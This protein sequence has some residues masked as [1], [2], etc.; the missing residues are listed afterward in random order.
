MFD[1][2][3]SSN[4]PK[5]LILVLSSQV[6]KFILTKILLKDPMKT[7]TDKILLNIQFIIQRIVCSLC[8]LKTLPVAIKFWLSIQTIQI[9]AIVFMY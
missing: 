6:N 8:L 9:L 2:D 3:I 1:K 4:K 5:I 7:Q